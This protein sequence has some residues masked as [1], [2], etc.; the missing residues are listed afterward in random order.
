M[1]ILYVEKAANAEAEASGNKTWQVDRVLDLSSA[2]A[3]S[4]F[5]SERTS[6]MP[7]SFRIWMRAPEECVGWRR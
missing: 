6:M 2:F 7:R 4:G 1:L 3:V 5:N